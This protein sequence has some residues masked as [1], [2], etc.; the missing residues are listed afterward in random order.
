M[1]FWD[2]LALHSL[3]RL[4]R[5]APAG[6][7]S[8]TE[9]VTRREIAGRDVRSRPLSVAEVKRDLTAAHFRL[10]GYMA[11]ADGRVSEEE[12]Q[13]A[14]AQIVS[15]LAGGGGG[16]DDCK[17]MLDGFGRGTARGFAPEDAASSIEAARNAWNAGTW[18]HDIR[19]DLIRTL[20][21]MA[22]AAGGVCPAQRQVLKEVAQGLDVPWSTVSA[23][24]EWQTQ[25][26]SVALEI[27]G[28]WNWLGV[29]PDASGGQ[30]RTAYRNIRNDYLRLARLTLPEEIHEAAR[31]AIQELEK[32]YHLIQEHRTT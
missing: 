27:E 2:S 17:L 24:L 25:A 22:N 31:Q 29:A 10:L 18:S 6:P 30:L 8:A 12:K 4:F 5:A 1:S 3:L 15:Q 19:L 11:K 9:S 21:A 14:R 32:A 28:A 13:L 7:P 20:V 23:E 16:P 26:A